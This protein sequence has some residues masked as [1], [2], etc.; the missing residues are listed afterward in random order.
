LSK[1]KTR[2]QIF[3]KLQTAG[4][5]DPSSVEQKGSKK[6]DMNRVIDE[7]SGTYTDT[8]PI[9][10]NGMYTKCKIGDE[11][12]IFLVD[13]GS[14]AT[15]M[16]KSAYIKIKEEKRPILERTE[17]KLKGANGQDIKVNG[18]VQLKLCF[19]KTNNAHKTAI[20]C[21]IDPDGTLR[22]DFLLTHATSIDYKRPTVNTKNFQIRCWIGGEAECRVTSR[23]KMI[24]PAMTK[25]SVKVSIENVENLSET[26]LLIADAHFE[27]NTNLRV[28]EGVLDPHKDTVNVI[29]INASENPVHGHENV[30]VGKCESY[31]EQ[32]EPDEILC[33][34]IHEADNDNTLP[35]HLKD[36][37]ERSSTELDLTNVDT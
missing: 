11:E 23:E 16:S 15:L 18:K 8:P 30:T 22:Q 1:S 34:H 29:L 33:N 26:G 24:I 25:A 14:S 17:N 3:G 35:E 13:N 21:D 2:K 9:W 31:F 27:N 37:L 20:I 28:V 36:L 4:I 32:K 6:V 12:H 10:D 19:D 7:R 5:E